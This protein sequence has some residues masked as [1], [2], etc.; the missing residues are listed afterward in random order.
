MDNLALSLRITCRV[1]ESLRVNR[2]RTR[3]AAQGAYSNATELADYL[4]R[5]GVPFRDAHTMVG[6]IVRRAIDKGVA[7]EDLPMAD[8]AAIAPQA[9][10]DFHVHLTIDA[11][12]KKRNVLGGTAPQQV[13]DAMAKASTRKTKKSRRAG[14]VAVKVVPACIDHVEAICKLVDY[15]AVQGENLPRS[16]DEVVESLTDFGV[17]LQDGRVIGCGC[18]HLYTST[19]AEIRSLGV[20]PDAKGHGVG[21]RMVEYFLECARRLHIRRVFVLTR[22]PDFFL[23][24][25]FQVVA[26]DTLPE[27]VFK[28]CLKCTKRDKCDEIAMICELNT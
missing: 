7:L 17:A 11:S 27:K 22:A 13:H 2:E 10:S 4:A 1:I 3:L 14:D 26:I 6:R 18:L 20:D 24:N 8:I 9:Q 19:L 15:W 25:G 23:R 28:D 12:L 16:R 5:Q 21:S